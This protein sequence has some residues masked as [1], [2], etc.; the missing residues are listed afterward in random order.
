MLILNK[1]GCVWFKYLG[2]YVGGDFNFGCL[3]MD[4][5]CWILLMDMGNDVIYVLDWDMWLLGV[6]DCFYGVIG[7][8]GI[9]VDGEDWVW[10][11]ECYI[12]KFK[13]VII[14]I[15]IV[16]KVYFI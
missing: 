14:S 16:V 13:V 8:V 10:V 6:I 5:L 3:V 12:V 11:M 4:F 1:V 9:V 15:R 7:C 2:G